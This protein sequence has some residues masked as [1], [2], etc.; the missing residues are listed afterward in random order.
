MEEMHKKVVKTKEGLYMNRGN[1]AASYAN[2]SSLQQQVIFM[3]KPIRE[4]AITDIISKL[5]PKTITITDLGCSSG[6]NALLVSSEIIHVIHSISAKLGQK[7]PEIQ[8]F[9]NDLPGNDFNNLF[10]L[11]SQ[12]HQDCPIISTEEKMLGIQQRCYHSGVPGSFYQ[13]LFP[14]ESLHF[15]HSSFSLH[16]IS[17]VPEGVL[18]RNQCNIYIA[19]TS[20]TMVVEAYYNQFYKDFSMFLKYRSIELVPGGRMIFTMQGRKSK[21]AREDGHLMFELLAE[22]ISD[23]VSKGLIEE[24]KLHSFNLP[25]Y[26]PSTSEIDNLVKEDGSFI[27]DHLDT[28]EVPWSAHANNNNESPSCKSQFTES[29][30]VLVI[31]AMRSVVE[32]QLINHFHEG[33]LDEMFN[34][35][36]KKIV[37]C[38]AKQKTTYSI[39]VV[40]M[41]KKTK[42]EN[43]GRVL[44]FDII[45]S[46]S[47][48]DC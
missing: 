27:I 2:N 10:K 13:R 19:K 41:Q 32:P 39:I 26:T 8:V 35:F 46:T 6:P 5:S 42:M 47:V 23:M 11:I 37:D 38:M 34:R 17:Q 18:K 7:H 14:T 25:V 9:L 30:G 16:W 29:D 48:I 43:Y 36:H 33:L 40:S 3:T 22:A 12:L 4:R 20:P 28:L 31:R 44:P 24:E 1:G 15:A 21:D 45:N